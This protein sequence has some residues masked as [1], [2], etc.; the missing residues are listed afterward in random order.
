MTRARGCG[1]EGTDG[2]TDEEGRGGRE[3]KREREREIKAGT[4]ACV[5]PDQAEAAESAYQ[6][7]NGERPIT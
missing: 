1:G 7:S 2:R 5:K 6:G 3:R 4:E